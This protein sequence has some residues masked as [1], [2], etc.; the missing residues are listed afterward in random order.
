MLAHAP[1]GGAGGEELR[2]HLAGQRLHVVGDGHLDHRRALH[3]A[4]GDRVERDVDPRQRRGVG[5]HGRLVQRVDLGVR[6]R[7]DDGALGGEG[8][9]DGAADRAARAVDHR[10]SALE[11]H[12]GVTSSERPE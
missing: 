2:A 7:V 5:V 8:P 1:H 9:G 3:V 12:S 4:D 11:D 10:V 6:G